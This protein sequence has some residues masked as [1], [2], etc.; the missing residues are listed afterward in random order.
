MELQVGHSILGAPAALY[1]TILYY[2]VRYSR[3]ANMNDESRSIPAS[4]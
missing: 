3:V 2:T 1:Y 4:E